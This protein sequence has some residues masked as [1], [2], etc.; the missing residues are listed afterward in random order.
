MSPSHKSGLYDCSRNWIQRKK[1][2]G[3]FRTQVSRY[4]VFIIYPLGCLF[5]RSNHHVGRKLK[6]HLKRPT[7]REAMSL[8]HTLTDFPDNS[9]NLP[10]IWVS[11]HE[12][13]SASLKSICPSWPPCWVDELSLLS[14]KKNCIFMSK[15]NYF[16]LLK[17]LN[18][19]ADYCEAIYNRYSQLATRYFCNP[20]I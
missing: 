9:N 16:L 11:H 4:W 1:H 7:W 20:K 10:G 17:C 13:E 8:A 6:Q 18:F 2:Y 12:S 5:L 15:I 3:S 19:R 14:T